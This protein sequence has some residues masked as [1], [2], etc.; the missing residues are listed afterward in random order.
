[1]SFSKAFGP[2]FL[3]L[4]LSST[5]I[6]KHFLLIFEDAG[7]LEKLSPSHAKTRF[8]CFWGHTFSQFSAH[9]SRSVPGSTFYRF[10][11]EFYWFWDSIWAP[12]G[13]LSG[14]IFSGL[15]NSKMLFYG[16]LLRRG[17]LR[18]LRE[19]G[20]LGGILE[21]RGQRRPRGGGDW[22]KW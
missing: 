16:S 10:F 14:V 15:K 3:D 13:R 11:N 6:L 5:S 1:M 19:K 17:H 8:R 18:P 12:W 2:Q 4:G 9:V 20:E 22:K 7:N 21:A